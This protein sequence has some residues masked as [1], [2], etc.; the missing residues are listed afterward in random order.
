MSAFLL[1]APFPVPFQ[2]LTLIDYGDVERG[3]RWSPGSDTIGEPNNGNALRI[4][5]DSVVSIV[6]NTW[7]EQTHNKL[8]NFNLELWRLRGS[9]ANMQVMQ[10]LK[11][12]IDWINE[13]QALR[14]TELS[15][16]LI[17]VF[18][19]DENREVI[20]ARG[21]VLTAHFEDIQGTPRTAYSVQIGCQYVKIYR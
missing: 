17:P 7:G 20:T 19:D 13:Q 8:T 21:G 2:K 18:G 12:L 3:D 14:F 1:S 15:N 11:Q 5:G 9:N 4:S 16:P 10:S 6:K